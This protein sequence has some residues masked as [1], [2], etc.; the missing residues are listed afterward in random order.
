MMESRRSLSAI[1]SVPGNRVS[2]GRR[3][4]RHRQ[5]VGRFRA[6]LINAGPLARC[7][8]V[9]P[10]TRRAAL[11]DPTGGPDCRNR[12]RLRGFWALAVPGTQPTAAGMPSSSRLEGV[13]GLRGAF[14]DRRQIARWEPCREADLTGNS[15]NR[16]RHGISPWDVVIRRGGEAGF[17]LLQSVLTFLADADADADAGWQSFPS[18]FLSGRWQ[19]ERFLAAEATNGAPIDH[20]TAAAR[21]ADAWQWV[22][23]T[24]GQPVVRPW[25]DPGI[26][27]R[28]AKGVWP[29]AGEAR[30]GTANM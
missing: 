27:G 2:T 28:P 25:G 20:T 10:P 24:S 4:N 21:L 15:H 23:G 5:S 14:E 26:E 19:N 8:A 11:R 12:Q 30:R 17:G 13:R 6:E 1:C 16:S 7:A 9:Q 3:P 22:R 29:R 18:F